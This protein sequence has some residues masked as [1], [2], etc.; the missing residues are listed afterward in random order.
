MAD[1][2]TLE[3]RQGEAGRA[4]ILQSL[5]IASNLEVLAARDLGD[6]VCRGSEELWPFRSTWLG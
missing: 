2:A 1:K 5:Q 3:V 6:P 4:E